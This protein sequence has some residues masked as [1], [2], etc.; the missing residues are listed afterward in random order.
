LEQALTVYCDEDFV[1]RPDPPTFND[2]R[3]R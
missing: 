2:R 1:N 3:R